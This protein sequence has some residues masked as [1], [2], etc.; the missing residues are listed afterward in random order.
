MDFLDSTLV[1]IPTLHW[2]TPIVNHQKI[3]TKESVSI[4]KVTKHGSHVAANVMELPSVHIRG[5]HAYYDVKV[6][7]QGEQI[8]GAM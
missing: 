4:K 1:K 8:D 2:L 7:L 3:M 6:S 5:K